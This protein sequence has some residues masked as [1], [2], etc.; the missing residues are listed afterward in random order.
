MKLTKS[1]LRN[2]IKEELD[3]VVAGD[4]SFEVDPPHGA[5]DA[6]WSGTPE[7]GIIELED[8]TT[9]TV[10]GGPDRASLEKVAAGLA[11]MGVE[12]IADS[13]NRGAP[14]KVL[15][16]LITKHLAGNIVDIP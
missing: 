6:Q 12:S 14:E 7:K 2:I 3:Q 1:Y 5:I 16:F 15:D 8:G 11:A 4:P 13:V 9:I 10:Y